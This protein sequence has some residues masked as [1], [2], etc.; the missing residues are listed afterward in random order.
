V[1]LDSAGHGEEAIAVLKDNLAR[2]PNDRDT[3]LALVT[4]S[5]DQGDPVTA[6]EYAQ[7]LTRVVN[8]IPGLASLIGTLRKQIKKPDAS[9]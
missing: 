5:R 3:L 2:H 1:G 4:F 7:Q 8:D 9:P 6:L